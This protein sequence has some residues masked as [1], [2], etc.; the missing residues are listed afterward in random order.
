MSTLYTPPGS[1][2]PKRKPSSKHKVTEELLEPLYRPADHP[3][4]NVKPF[5]TNSRRE[6][7]PLVLAPKKKPSLRILPQQ[8]LRVQQHQ[9]PLFL[10]DSEDQESRGYEIVLGRGNKQ[11]RGIPLTAPISE[12]IKEHVLPIPFPQIQL[13]LKWPGYHED[14]V[15]SSVKSSKGRITAAMVV[16]KTC[17]MV[18]DLE[19]SVKEKKLSLNKSKDPDW[20]LSSNMSSHIIRILKLIHIENGTYQVELGVISAS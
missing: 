11:D 10:P 6:V 15:F 3:D 12:D 7:R 20:I 9:Q 18:L 5:R 14:Y 8:R 2:Y 4:G 17:R 16:D 1:P 19:R 13:C